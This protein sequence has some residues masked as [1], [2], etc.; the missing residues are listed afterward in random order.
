VTGEPSAGSPIA[1]YLRALWLASAVLAFVNLT[2]GCVEEP[3]VS[4]GG[5][6]DVDG[7]ID[8][9]TTT[10]EAERERLFRELAER[11]CREDEPVCGADG[12]S[13]RNYCQAIA[14][15]T[16]IAHAGGC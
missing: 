15:G 12:I 8:E 9:D 13:Y 11:E 3:I 14:S 6:A 2:S 4:L 7:S 10:D 1:F 5:A 16:Q